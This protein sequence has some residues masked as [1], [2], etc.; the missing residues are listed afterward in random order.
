MNLSS[1]HR[2]KPALLRSYLL[3]AC[4]LLS[5][6]GHLL[7]IA[8]LRDQS[9]LDEPA[10][11]P[12][13][14]E[15]VD[16]PLP[17]ERQEEEDPTRQPTY[18]IDQPPAPPDPD[19][20]VESERRAERDQRVEREQA[21]EGDDVRDQRRA[22]EPASS[23]PAAQPS[24]P[25]EPEP[26]P[27]PPTAAPAT[28]R[29]SAPPLAQEDSGRAPATEPDDVRDAADVP[30]E[31]PP[32]ADPPQLTR[33]QLFPD[34]RVLQDIARGDPA[35]RDRI[36]ERDDVE[37]G[38]EVWLN[39]QHDRLVSF[40]RRFHDRVDRVWNYPSEAIANG[41][42][43]TLELLII[44]TR[45]GELVDVDLRR[46]SGSDILDFEAIQAVYRAAPFGPLGRH[47]PHEQLRIRANFRYRIAGRYIFGR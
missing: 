22:A 20:Q 19:L 41:V 16:Y 6:L 26:Q 42:E 36:R 30:A 12:T 7:I 28:P 46:S 33:E 23:P 18:E 44:V 5:L 29:P 38:D 2:S 47:Y 25:L 11:Q 32:V 4:L 27:T 45:E 40:F 9:P 31:S 13:L 17:E 1:S 34:S 15:L 21:P 10:P 8:V 37:I 3:L 14:I 24:P 39:L 35:E 43:G